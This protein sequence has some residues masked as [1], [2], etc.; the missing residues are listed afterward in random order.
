MH[1]SNHSMRIEWCMVII[2]I[3]T[4]PIV[5]CTI[6]VDSSG[7]DRDGCGTISN[8]CGT[9]VF[10][11]AQSMYSEIFTNISKIDLYITGQNEQEIS[12]WNDHNKTT[13]DISSLNE[14]EFQV[15]AGEDD[16][17]GSPCV[18]YRG[19]DKDIE[20]TFDSTKIRSMRDWF[21]DACEQSWHY[22]NLFLREDRST[23]EYPQISETIF[24]NLII[25]DVYMDQ[26]DG[27]GWLKKILNFDTHHKLVLNNCIFSNITRTSNW[28]NYYAASLAKIY[29]LMIMSV[30][31]ISR[32][33]FHNIVINPPDIIYD[34]PDTAMYELIEVSGSTSSVIELS[35]RMEHCSIINYTNMNSEAPF[36]W[37]YAKNLYSDT[38]QID[39]INSSFSGIVTS[40]ALI[41]SSSFLKQWRVVIN[42][43]S[44][45]FLDIN[46]GSILITQNV[47]S[48]LITDTVITTKQTVTNLIDN[49]FD[50]HEL[51]LFVFGND[52][53]TMKNVTL[54]Y[55]YDLIS[56]CNLQGEVQ[57][58][59]NGMVSQSL[60]RC[61][62]PIQ[63]LQN[64]GVV[65]ITGFTVSND[66]EYHKT[67]DFYS[68]TLFKQCAFRYDAYDGAFDYALIT[69]AGELAI[70]DFF[71]R[72][73]GIHFQLLINKGNAFVSNAI[74][75]YAYYHESFDPFTLNNHILFRNDGNSVYGG[76]LEIH[77]SFLYGASY[78][79][80]YLVKGSASISNTI[81]QRSQ[82]ALGA[83]PG[84]TSLM[85]DNVQFRNIGAFYTSYFSILL[86][87]T[88][89]PPIAISAKQSV[90][91]NSHFSLFDMH[92][93][94]VCSPEIW[95]SV[96][97]F[98]LSLVEEESYDITLINNSFE[99]STNNLIITIQDAQMFLS[100]IGDTLK[101]E[102][103][104][105][106]TQQLESLR[107]NASALFQ[108]GCIICIYPDT[109]LQM[110]GNTFYGNE[111]SDTTPFI[112]IDN[113]PYTNC[114]S[115]NIIH[116]YALQLFSGTV[117]SCNRY[118]MISSLEVATCWSGSLGQ[119][120]D[121]YG[122]NV[123]DTDYF[124][125][126]PNMNDRPL[127]SL[128]SVDSVFAAE[129]ISF[130]KQT[131]GELIKDNAIRVLSG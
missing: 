124:I 114:I 23:P 118:D 110:I 43:I 93:M 14:W 115:S 36:V 3:C 38:R 26:I 81:I 72:G 100:L 19:I 111:L 59:A 66:V 94:I 119:L 37:F 62:V 35:F 12:V 49:G 83:S 95:A 24:N 73:V 104:D 82:S 15:N 33:S 92:G 4:I 22:Y 32:T 2:L 65:N 11:T 34:A 131:N 109:T 21:P 125:A 71:I 122:F 116:G 130:V 121:T 70:S 10:A 8:P 27:F 63:L 17:S 107:F 64:E 129:R 47:H 25:S 48:V 60:Y 88:I 79:A 123:N 16:I 80:V 108:F 61:Y 77:N 20:I 5:S 55:Q 117:T 42:I 97:S 45:D 101:T 126:T 9:I 58:Y 74:T 75:E 99:L 86:S 90:V 69:N 29:P 51:S 6:F 18:F 106:A 7:I 89:L 112:A 76:I 13:T 57:S 103:L 78:I 56:S 54:H 102:A 87:P 85:V 84:V 67:H 105:T 41:M 52:D 50:A 28:Y 127:I 40:S 30:A 120:Y 39:V 44:C 98:E 96:L 1:S 46:L 91:K 53:I 68:C 128:Q 113:A 31:N